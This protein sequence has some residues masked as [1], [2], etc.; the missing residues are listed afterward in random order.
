MYGMESMT[1]RMDKS[2]LEVLHAQTRGEVNG[3]NYSAVVTS[4]QQY[5][6]GTYWP[7]VVGKETKL[8]ETRTTVVSYLGE[9]GMQDETGTETNTWTYTVDRV[10]EITVTAGTFR[11]FVIVKRDDSGDKVQTDWYSDKV[12]RYVKRTEHE[13]GD[14]TELKSYSL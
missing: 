2:T 12:G 8:V 3:V 14:T 11:C 13:S 6:D 4:Q 1:A 7:L 9:S 10:E 5:L